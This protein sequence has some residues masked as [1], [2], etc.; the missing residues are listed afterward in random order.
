MPST[1]R[2][3]EQQMFGHCNNFK[4]L[5]LIKNYNGF[6]LKTTWAIITIMTGRLGSNEA[7]L[8]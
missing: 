2:D 7:T 6:G 3:V 1:N 8:H 5:L 4:R